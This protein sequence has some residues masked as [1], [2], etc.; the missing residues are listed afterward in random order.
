MG[1][2]HGQLD[3]VLCGTTDRDVSGGDQTNDGQS[4]AGSSAHSSILC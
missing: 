3:T 4:R 1:L 2:L